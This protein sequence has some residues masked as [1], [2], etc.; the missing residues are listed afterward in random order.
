MIKPEI[1][2][3]PKSVVDRIP[4]VMYIP[5]PPETTAEEKRGFQVPVSYP[6]KP[7]TTPSVHS[8]KHF[9]F[10]TNIRSFK[11]KKDKDVPVGS[12]EKNEE[13]EP[14]RPDTWEGNW[15]QG[16]YPLVVLEG[17]R[18]ACAI[19]LMDFEE[20]RRRIGTT[21]DGVTKLEGTVARENDLA[22]S[23]TS[24]VEIEQHD[25]AEQ[26]R[27]EDA[28]DGAQPLRLLS[29]GHVFHVSVSFHSIVYLTI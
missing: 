8:R 22:P 15:E 11:N 1:G 16:D 25:A 12:K 3:L 7:P 14:E 6:P 29:C 10:L 27:L 21:V 28:G 26:L 13:S 9:R 18:A 19:C 23:S 20:P 2:K 17:N 5:P 24:T 4:L